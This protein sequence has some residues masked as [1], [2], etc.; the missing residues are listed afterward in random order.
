MVTENVALGIL[1][2]KWM[3]TVAKIVKLWVIMTVANDK[4]K[5]VAYSADSA[6]CGTCYEN[7]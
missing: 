7:N 4:T 2:E 6:V 1:H 3:T 5:T